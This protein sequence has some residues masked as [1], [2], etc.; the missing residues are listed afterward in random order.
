M[1]SLPGIRMGICDEEIYLNDESEE[2]PRPV[3]CNESKNK[4]H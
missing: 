2:V 3:A 1:T 4:Y